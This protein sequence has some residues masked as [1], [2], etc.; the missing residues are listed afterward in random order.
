MSVFSRPAG[1]PAGI[2]TGAST[3]T[4]LAERVGVTRLDTL[5]TAGAQAE[6]AL[7]TRRVSDFS[8]LRQ[9]GAT[10]LEES[11]QVFADVASAL[12][13][14]AD[15]LETAQ[16]A[17]STAS[18]G[19]QEAER[20]WRAAR[21]MGEVEAETQAREDMNRHR[22]NASDAQ[23]DFDLAKSRAR[24]TLTGLATTWSPEGASTSA[25]DAWALSTQAIVPQE[26]GL[27]QEQIK[28][29]VRGET[30][31]QVLL[32]AGN[33]VKKALAN[34]WY[35]WTAISVGRD[36]AAYNRIATAIRESRGQ[37]G[38]ARAAL[39]A[40]R[41]AVGLAGANRYYGS[42]RRLQA[43]RTALANAQARYP[44]S[45]STHFRYNEIRSGAPRNGSGPTGFRGAMT[46]FGNSRIMTAARTGGRLLAP[47][48]AVTGAMDIYR[49][50]RGGD[51]MSTT[52]RVVTGIGGAGGLAA[53]GLAT[54]ALV[55]G[56]ALGPVGLG[57]I[58]VGGAVAA[59]A[60][61]YQNREA[62][63][64]TAKKAWDGAKNV[65]KKVWK[66]LFG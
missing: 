57:I 6:A 36:T 16:S 39:K 66:G 54:Y 37:G 32:D 60:W 21:N 55:A 13:D 40:Q 47:L 23:D 50:I 9:D 43:D 51:G 35:A 4:R 46:R 56:A 8:G 18:S 44:R 25:V 48:G 20:L 27:D 1:D 28:A 65:G 33:K 2:R 62:V 3:L 64:H 61:L 45:H 7:P 24:T 30:D 63:V 38:S 29:W 49:A 10:A 53:G 12:A 15:A 11:G 42:M 19:Y 58:A 26:V 41:R 17:V 14:Y 31:A 34:G 22:S 5:F 59:G 52:D